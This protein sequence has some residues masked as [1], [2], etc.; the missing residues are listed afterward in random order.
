MVSLSNHIRTVV[1]A[2]AGEPRPT[3]L[4]VSLSH[5]P[6]NLPK[7]RSWVSLSNHSVAVVPAK[8]GEPRPTRFMVSPSRTVISL[9]L[10]EGLASP[11]SLGG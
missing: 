7:G 1:P 4:M 11:R 9:I 3:P 10:V 2:K 5:H 6:L 8:A